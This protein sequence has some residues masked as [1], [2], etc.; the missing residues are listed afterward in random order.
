MFEEGAGVFGPEDESVHIF[1]EEAEAFHLVWIVRVDPVEVT[2]FDPVTE[3]FAEKSGNVRPP[4]GA[5]NQY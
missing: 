5:D 2:G 4:A 1:R 3:P